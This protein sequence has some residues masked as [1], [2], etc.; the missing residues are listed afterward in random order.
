MKTSWNVINQN[1]HIIIRDIKVEDLTF[2]SFERET[3]K[4]TEILRERE[5]ERKTQKREAA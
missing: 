1:L 5:R 2:K 3:G 4:E